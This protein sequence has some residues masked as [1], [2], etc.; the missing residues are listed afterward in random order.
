MIRF[1]VVCATAMAIANIGLSIA[2]TKW[3]GVAGPVLGTVVA[4]TVFSTVPSLIYV[5]RMWRK[6]KVEAPA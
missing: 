1:Q 4:Q 3:L 2:F 5:S 6:S